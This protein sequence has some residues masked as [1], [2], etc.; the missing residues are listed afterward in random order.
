MIQEF[1]ERSFFFFL[2]PHKCIL[3]PFRGSAGLT[4]PFSQHPC[5]GG[6][7]GFKYAATFMVRALQNLELVVIPVS[8]RALCSNLS[9]PPLSKNTPPQKNNNESLPLPKSGHHRAGQRIQ[10]ERSEEKGCMS[11]H[12]TRTAPSVQL[13]CRCIQKEKKRK[14]TDSLFFSVSALV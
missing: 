1:I 10:R 7:L 11:T 9:S 2:N 3:V 5:W 6:A 12:T 4:P 14:K 13:L 8:S